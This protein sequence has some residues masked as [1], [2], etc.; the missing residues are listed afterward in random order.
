MA[1]VL[2]LRTQ[3][4]H[5]HAPLR[6]I[7]MSCAGAGASLRLTGQADACYPDIQRKREIVSALV[8]R[9]RGW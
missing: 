7:I 5:S 4:A 8:L 9:P 1:G 3:I 6:P 2:Q